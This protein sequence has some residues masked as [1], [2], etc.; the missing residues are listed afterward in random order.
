MLLSPDLASLYLI[1]LTHIYLFE[2]CVASNTALISKVYLEHKM[3][4]LGNSI[5]KTFQ[6]ENEKSSSRF[7]LFSR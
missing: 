3:L 1:V 2:I 7:I 4:Y 6:K 5:V